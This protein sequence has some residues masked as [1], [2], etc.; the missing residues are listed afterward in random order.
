MMH[1]GSLVS[2]KQINFRISIYTIVGDDFV[3]QEAIDDLA[4]VKIDV[5]GF[6]YEVLNG[7]KQTLK[8]QRPLIFCEMNP[9][10]RRFE[11]IN[12][13]LEEVDYVI[14]A[15]GKNLRA[16]LVDKLPY[17]DNLGNDFVLVHASRSAQFEKAMNSE[18]TQKI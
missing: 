3:A 8:S 7:L 13:L 2:R 11:E 1:Q 4:L 16:L 9:N 17:K 18:P 14:F 10:Q 15:Q 6:E 12:T 5:E